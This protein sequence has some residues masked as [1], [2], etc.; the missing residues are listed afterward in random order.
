MPKLK[1]L[2]SKE[3]SSLAHSMHL[4][5]QQLVTEIEKVNNQF[6]RHQAILYSMVE[7]VISVDLTGIIISCNEAAAAA[8]VQRQKHELLEQH[9]KQAIRYPELADMLK[10][11]VDQ[12]LKHQMEFTTYQPEQ[13][14]L[15]V[16]G[17]GLF[18]DEQDRIGS[19]FVLQDITER[20]QFEKLRKEFVSNVSHEL[21]TPLNQY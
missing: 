6:R 15:I 5:G 14:E 16:T 12:G 17:Y 20:K 8:M 9:I 18:N 10:E 2:K 11:V 7:G 19:V 13:R 21:K 3:F 1:N 4:M